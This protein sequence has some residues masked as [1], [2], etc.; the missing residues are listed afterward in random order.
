MFLQ[1]VKALRNALAANSELNVGVGGQWYLD[2]AQAGFSYPYGVISLNAG[3]M[4]NTAGTR[5]GDLRFLVKVIG[6]QQTRTHELAELVRQALHEQTLTAAEPW[7]IWRC[8]QISSIHL[9]EVDAQVA[10]WH[11]GGIYR[12]RMSGS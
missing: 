2:L 4:D 7:H 8:Q 3:G 6:N 10:Y 12:I 11:A 1:A 9:M 5:R